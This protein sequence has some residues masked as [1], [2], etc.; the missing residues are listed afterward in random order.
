MSEELTYAFTKED[1]KEV[2]NFCKSYHLEETKKGAGR[3]GSG[4]RGFGGEIDAFGPGKLREIGI[5]KIISKLSGKDCLIDNEIYSNY[6]VGQNVNA[7]I[8]KIKDNNIERDPNLYVEIKPFFQ[9]DEW[10]GMRADQIESIER[11]HRDK[12]NNTY[13][14]YGEILYDDKKN[15]KER[16]FLGAFLKSVLVDENYSFEEFSNITDIKCKIHYAF[17]LKDLK[18]L[19]HLYPKETIIPETR[20]RI[21]KQIFNKSGKLW[22]G[23]RKIKHISGEKN[24]KANTLPNGKVLDYG[25]FKFNG[26]AILIVDNKNKHKQYLFFEDKSI[27]ENKYFGTFKFKK[28]EAVSFNIRNKLEGFQGSNVKGIDD[29]WISRNRLDQLID[30][31]KFK[32]IHTIMKDI[33]TKI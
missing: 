25:K 14:I 4:P 24:I 2:I 11:K 8:I 18:S 10:Y 13:L 20:F 12:L 31:G 19:G 15:R 23:K 28:G 3:T 21:A 9:N 32:K 6:K 7:D 17:S 33:A 27:L 30:E 29:W 16:D 26:K 1:I 5:S 22:K